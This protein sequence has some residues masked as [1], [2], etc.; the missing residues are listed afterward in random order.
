MPRLPA[1]LISLG[2]LLCV[3]SAGCSTDR[4]IPAPH[5]S[6]PTL[7]GAPPQGIAPKETVMAEVLELKRFYTPGGGCYYE[8]RV[9]VRNTGESTQQSLVLRLNFVHARDGSVIDTRNI[10][11]G[12]MKAGESKIFGEKERFA[13]DCNIDYSIIP[14]VL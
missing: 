3:L 13:G 11:V 2:I 4:G 8:S 5:T 1:I 6:A 9:E 12:P 10:P 14:Y 7:N